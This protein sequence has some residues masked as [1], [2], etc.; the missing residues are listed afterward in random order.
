MFAAEAVPE[1]NPCGLHKPW[2]FHPEGNYISTVLEKRWRKLTD[3]RDAL[4]RKKLD[5]QRAERDGKNLSL[6]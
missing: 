6:S 3:I 4:D 5:M 2:V 1:V